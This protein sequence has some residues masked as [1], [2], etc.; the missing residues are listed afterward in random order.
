MNPGSFIRALRAFAVA[1][2]CVCVS[3]SRAEVV[4]IAPSIDPDTWRLALYE[5][6]IH[7]ITPLRIYPESITAP[8]GLRDERA[9]DSW[10][11][12]FFL[13]RR[14]WNIVEVDIATG[15][16]ARTLQ[17]P[18][19][20]LTRFVFDRASNSLVGIGDD[21][22]GGS[23]SLTRLSLATGELTTLNGRLAI[24]ARL[25]SEYAHDSR[26]GLLFLKRVDGW[27]SVVDAANGVVLRDL[28]VPQGA[29]GALHFDEVDSRLVGLRDSGVGGDLRLV[30]I[31]VE[32]AELRVKDFWP[33]MGG[34]SNGFSTLDVYTRRM[35][36]S[37]AP[38]YLDMFGI[39]GSAPFESANLH[40]QVQS[41]MTHLSPFYKAPSM[42]AIRSVVGD[43]G[44]IVVWFDSY[45]RYGRAE[46]ESYVVNCT[47]NENG[48]P[49]IAHGTGSPIRVDGL[50]NGATYRCNVA[51]INAFGTGDVSWPSSDVV[52][53]AHS[54]D[55][56]CGSA[57]G[58]PSPEFP[59]GGLCASGNPTEFTSDDNFNS[60]RCVG[61]TG[62]ESAYCSAPRVAVEGSRV[63]WSSSYVTV[64]E[65][66]GEIEVSAVR[67]YNLDR[68][69]SV[70]YETISGTAAAADDYGP[71]SGVIQFP[72]GAAFAT[73]RLPI[74]RDVSVEGQEYFQVVLGEIVE[75]SGEVTFPSRVSVVI[76][77]DDSTTIR[78]PSNEYTVVEGLP[79]RIE[80]TR[81]G[82]LNTAFTVPWFVRPGGGRKA[83]VTS[84]TVEFPSGVSSITLSIPTVADAVSDAQPSEQFGIELGSPS[85]PNVIVSGYSAYVRVMDDEYNRFGFLSNVVIVD[86]GATANLT[87][88]RSGNL[89]RPSSLIWNTFSG[90]ASNSDFVPAEG[91]VHFA[92]GQATATISVR[93]LPDNIAE[94][95][96]NAE[97]FSVQL[98]PI[99]DGSTAAGRVS[100]T[101][102]I[103]DDDGSLITIDQGTIAV[104]EG[105]VA[106][107]TVRRRGNLAGAVQVP[108]QVVR[109]D[110]MEDFANQAGQVVIPA[111]A[112]SAIISVQTR[113]NAIPEGNRFFGVQIDPPLSPGA[114][115][116][117][118]VWA[119]GIV[120]D[121]DGIVGFDDAPASVAETAGSV[122]LRIRREAGS[123]ASTV[124]TYSARNGTAKAGTDFGARGVAT[125]TGTFTL[126]P[127]QEYGLLSIPILDSPT[128]TGPREFTVTIDRVTN[129]SVDPQHKTFTVMILE[130][131][132]GV[133]LASTTARVAESAGSVVVTVNRVG[134][135][136]GDVSVNWT[137]ANGSALAG[138]HFGAQGSTTQ[139]SGT[140]QWASGDASP[141]TVAIPIFNDGAS[142]SP[143]TFT[144][145]L[146]SAVGAAI[147]ANK[148]ATITID[149]DDNV[150]QFNSPTRSVVESVGNIVLTVARAGGT[151]N[152]ASVG[153]ATGNGTAVAGT[154]FGTAGNAAGSNGVL[155]WS[156]GDS[157]AKTITIPIINNTVLSG[158][159]RTFTVT[160]GTPTG[161]NIGANATTTVTIQDDEKGVVMAAATYQV[162]ESAANVVVMV[163]RVGDAAAALSVP[164][165]TS[166]GTAAAGTRFGVRGNTAQ[167]TG[168]LTWPVGDAT[169]KSIAI[170]IVANVVSDGDAEFSV[171]LGAVPNGFIKG[172]PSS[173]VVT[174]RDDDVA[175][176]SI[177]E[178]S[179]SKTVVME[180]SGASAI[181]GLVR[182]VHP[183]CGGANCN[184]SRAV[185][186][187][188]S[189]LPGTALAGSD[190]VSIANGTVEFASG[191]A[192]KTISVGI[193]NNNVVEEPEYFI[194]RLGSPSPG[195]TLGARSESSVAIQD[196][197]EQFPPAGNWPAGW[198]V[199]DNPGSG[200]DLGWHVTTDPGAAEGFAA[201]RTDTLFNGESAT[202]DSPLR[203]HQAGTVAFKYRVSSELGYDWL[204]FYRCDANGDCTKLAEWS[205]RTNETNWAQANITVPKGLQR[206]RW[207]FEK[208]SA[209]SVGH[210]A[211]WIDA[212]SLPPLVQ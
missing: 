127:G 1:C 92:V 209:I 151:A 105:A 36:Q 132:K 30:E 183:S 11:R 86:E 205:G 161:A 41:P 189:T 140:V 9:V 51:A 8:G 185:S 138:T 123:G 20:S 178:F 97:E 102:E 46:V 77:D 67:R 40:F 69:L 48:V 13:M 120:T 39:G 64:L 208:D 118:Y 182:S 176:D 145:T 24:G 191:E 134:P 203:N 124:I 200:L 54:L 148:A 210:D 164:W 73:I 180:G 71:M 128:S 109:S 108:W 119:N 159:T 33:Q 155:T 94:D 194:V 65:G 27:I 63:G 25:S 57:S 61:A 141:R 125:H 68:P 70:R 175:N 202:V 76:A 133:Q 5:D 198:V 115:L 53:S 143:R 172:T 81:S 4:G 32:T 131:D 18:P 45:A 177:V 149:D 74:V 49:G 29:I 206:F 35:Y 2:L 106:R 111:G 38:T 192:S 201:M 135:P 78:L 60:W 22:A 152:A 28:P 99:D 179:S 181:I 21:G 15:A 136:D 42:P 104:T 158:G 187:K 66:Q 87:I 10:Q 58:V 157:A 12:R 168:T 75:G 195:L 154:D 96:V 197:D 110:A 117:G 3:P 56:I 101:V 31:D 129:G 43:S 14:D 103:R 6:Y 72:T 130:D 116:G 95:M 23:P 126:S 121:D 174:I 100:A 196:D 79:I 50:S 212:V 207:A 88:V 144:L 55:G 184:L 170:P 84:G 166:N 52:P 98:T 142:N 160:L 146:T 156:A 37:H 44:A 137:T 83:A 91:T 19:N 211:A 188:Y 7:S 190:F 90:A 62:G 204:R 162:Q 47:S 26:N 165:A 89:S 112:T 173:A 167:R 82:N 114:M 107:F 80:L 139:R 17:V 153:W 147:G 169:A 59:V 85:I 93:T 193:A 16:P 163:N 122:V 186:V 171:T 199:P 113:Q 150:V 34:R